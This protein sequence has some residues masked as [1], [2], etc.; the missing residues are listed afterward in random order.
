MQSKC[1]QWIQAGN[2]GGDGGNGKVCPAVFGFILQKSTKE[3]EKG[4]C[5]AGPLYQPYFPKTPKSF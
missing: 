1:R 5:P 4:K 3:K 2:V